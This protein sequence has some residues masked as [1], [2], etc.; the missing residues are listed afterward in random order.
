V[1]TRRIDG[2]CRTL[3]LP[4]TLTLTLS[5]T[6]SLTITI[7]I[8]LIAIVTFFIPTNVRKKDLS[9]EFRDSS[10]VTFPRTDSSNSPSLEGEGS[11]RDLPLLEREREKVRW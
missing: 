9:D 11:D 7:I 6:L 1:G 2:G 10:F 4:R 5:L 8:T 3:S